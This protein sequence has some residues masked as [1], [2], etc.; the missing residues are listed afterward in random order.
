[1]G[2]S[3]TCEEVT[4]LYGDEVESSVHRRSALL[5]YMRL[6]ER[7]ELA[8]RMLAMVPPSGD[9]LGVDGAVGGQHRATVC[10]LR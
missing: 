4:T 9:S 6:R 1:M 7:L 5:M 10:C 8:W 2:L 3:L